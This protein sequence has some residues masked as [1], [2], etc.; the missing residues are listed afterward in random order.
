MAKKIIAFDDA[1]TGTGLPTD[2]ETKMGGRF[3]TKTEASATYVRFRDTDGNPIP[4]HLVTITVNTTTGDI[5]DIT[6][7]EA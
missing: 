4:G 7:G 1:A 5:D 3:L 2:V 6:F